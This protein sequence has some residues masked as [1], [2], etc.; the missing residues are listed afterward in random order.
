MGPNATYAGCATNI[1]QWGK[2]TKPPGAFY[3]YNHYHHMLAVAAIEELSGKPAAIFL[4]EALADAGM[5]NSYWATMPEMLTSAFDVDLAPF[6][7]LGMAPPLVIDAASSLVTTPDDMEKFFMSYIT[8]SL[9]GIPRALYREWAKD[10]FTA[11]TESPAITNATDLR[12]GDMTWM[13]SYALGHWLGCSW[14]L[15]NPAGEDMKWS[16][17][18]DEQV[19][20]SV[21]AFGAA[22]FVD[23]ARGF[24]VQSSPHHGNPTSVPIK[25]S[26]TSMLIL[27]TLK[28]LLNKYAGHANHSGKTASSLKNRDPCHH[29]CCG[30]PLPLRASA[31]TE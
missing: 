3:Q 25:K 21:G 23:T 2:F 27:R 13:G 10:Y 24:I 28:L 11:T 17:C 29:L 7:M 30:G 12:V 15:H 9:P 31:V 4:A 16:W 14:T 19:E 1:L 18:H 20:H 6:A 8:Q 26:H 5:A 22:A